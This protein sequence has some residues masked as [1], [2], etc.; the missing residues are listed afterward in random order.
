[1]ACR[2]SG[3]NSR[4]LYCVYLRIGLWQKAFLTGYSPSSRK[5]RP[6]WGCQGGVK[7]SEGSSGKS[8]IRQAR[9]AREEG[10][11]QINSSNVQDVHGM[12]MF[13]WKCLQEAR[14]KIAT[15]SHVVVIITKEFES[16]SLHPIKIPKKNWLLI[17]I[18][19]KV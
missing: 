14:N 9:V 18:A 15:R 17:I 16:R 19:R 7:E 13:R 1:V 5:S 2:S 10:E 12:C 6:F 8:R 4:C 11:C 3:R